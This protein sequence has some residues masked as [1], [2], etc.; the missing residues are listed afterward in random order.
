MTEDLL[1]AAGGL[2]LF[3][4][5]MRMMTEGLRALAGNSLRQILRRYSATP[6]RGAVAGTVTTAMV[7]SSSATTVAAVGFVGAGLMT[8]QE[9]LGIIFGA[10]IGTTVTGWLVAI[11]GFK[12]QIGTVAMPLALIGV[13]MRMF[14]PG[15]WKEVG[16]SLAG[17]SV[18]FFGIDALQS[19][20]AAFQDVVTPDRFPA[21]SF[22]GRLQLVGIGIVVTIITQSSS[23]GVASALAALTAG[24]ITFPQAAALVI[25]MDVGT[26]FSAALATLGG[27]TAV[28]RTGWSHVIYNGLTGMMAFLLLWPLGW[29]TEGPEA[30]FPVGDPQIALVAFHSFFNILGVVLVLLVA[31]QFARLVEWLIPDR[32]GGLT[33]RLDRRLLVQPVAALDA[34]TATVTEL[35]GAHFDLIRRGL[36]EDARGVEPRMAE[37]RDATA[38]T[39]AHLQEV[40]ADSAAVLEN[41][42]ALLHALDHLD[43]LRH[44]CAQQERARAVRETPELSGPARAL[45]AAVA[46]DVFA[47]DAATVARCDGLRRDLHA[48]RES[49]RAA[50]LDATA[51][52]SF[53]GGDVALRLDAGR[54]LQRVAHHVW[55]I[56]H[57]LRIA[58][59]DEP[60]AGRIGGDADDQG[61][62]AARVS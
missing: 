9:S 40:R 42:V 16:W 55:R 12:L 5:G 43:R 24:A 30:P 23:A 20:M 2:G 14:A 49:D 58:A 28:R 29:L 47:A 54:W 36:T 21:D 11:L 41:Q 33:R 61:L 15:R 46:P 1:T 56:A 13:M 7:Q 4:I 26:T 48:L 51:R 59:T 37:L 10:N 50:V 32:R 25:G 6:L 45:L 38:E 35:A 18:L 62:T 44:R 3:L 34:A 52:G 31:A 27:S 19:G 60:I 22:F 53:S 17:F 8:F 57:H 39:R